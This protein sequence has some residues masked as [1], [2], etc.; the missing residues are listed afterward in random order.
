[1]IEAADGSAALDVIRRRDEPVDILLLDIT[2]P[3]TPSRE[4]F[5]EAKCLRP[6]M[7]VIVTSAYGPETAAQSLHANVEH[8]LRKP[9]PLAEVLETIR[10]TSQVSHSTKENNYRSAL[11]TP[12]APG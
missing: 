8:F 7:A 5:Q 12:R 3:G 4:V 11:A 1:M 6:A 2:L 9:Y 10:S